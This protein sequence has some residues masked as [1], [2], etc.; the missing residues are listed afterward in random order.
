MTKCNCF[1]DQLCFFRVLIQGF[2]RL[3]GP[4]HC[5][6]KVPEIRNSCI[7]FLSRIN[8]FIP[9]IHFST[10]DC[11]IEVLYLWFPSSWCRLQTS[12]YL[13]KEVIGMHD[14]SRGILAVLLTH[15]LKMLIHSRAR[16]L[17][18]ISSCYK[19]LLCI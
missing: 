12:H 11:K 10:A 18:G 13:L 2:H 15:K 3:L 4:V 17:M 19:N 16:T 7:C 5:L 8:K 14:L 1:H 9:R 6:Y